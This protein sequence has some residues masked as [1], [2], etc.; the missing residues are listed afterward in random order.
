M[1]Y[2]ALKTF[3]GKV[4]MAEGEVREISDSSIANDL[5]QAGYVEEV[6]DL[7]KAGLNAEV[8]PVKKTSSSKKSKK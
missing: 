6:K 4:S 5:L 2:K 1:R 7:P 8:K 3:G